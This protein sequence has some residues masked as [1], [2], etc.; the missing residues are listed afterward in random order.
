MPKLRMALIVVFALVFALVFA[1]VLAASI[2]LWR[3]KWPSLLTGVLATIVVVTA[4]SR[5]GQYEVTRTCLY[6]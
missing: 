2:G 1:M 4:S 3:L 5:D 6:R